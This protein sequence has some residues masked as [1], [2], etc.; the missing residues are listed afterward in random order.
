[1]ANSQ[2]C[3]ARRIRRWSAADVGCGRQS[4]VPSPAACSVDTRNTAADATDA[5]ALESLVR[6]QFDAH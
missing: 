1:M 4:A 3:S 6:L 5:L 2:T